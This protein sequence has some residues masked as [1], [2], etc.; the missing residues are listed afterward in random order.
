AQAMSGATASKIAVAGALAIAIS[1]SSTDSAIGDSVSIDKAGDSS[2]QASALS[3]TSNNTSEL[4]AKAWAGS[5]SS[6]GSGVG[7]S[8]AVVISTDTYSAAIGQGDVINAASVNVQAT[9]E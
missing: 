9:N 6:Q 5:F 4:A 2:P 3:V 1:T 7:A 8:I